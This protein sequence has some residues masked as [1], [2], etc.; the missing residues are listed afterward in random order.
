MVAPAVPYGQ[1]A[2]TPQAVQ[3]PKADIAA[4]SKALQ[5]MAMQNK[6]AQ[7]NMGMQ[8]VPTSAEKAT[9][10]GVQN[11]QSIGRPGEPLEEAGDWT[12]SIRKKKDPTSR[13]RDLVTG[14]S[15]DARRMRE[16]IARIKSDP[17]LIYQ[18]KDE[19]LQQQIALEV[20]K[21]PGLKDRVMAAKEV[22]AEKPAET[23]PATTGGKKDDATPPATTTGGK[24]DDATPPSGK[25]DKGQQVDTSA[26]ADAP[27]QWNKGV[28][29]YGMGL[30]G[31][32]N[33]DVKKM[34]EKLKSL[35]YQVE[36]DGRFGPET[37]K[38]VIQFQ[39]D[40]KIK[41]DGAAGPRT[42]P[43]LAAAKPAKPELIKVL[44]GIK[45][46]YIDQ[47]KYL[48]SLDDIELTFTEDALDQLAENTM[49]LKTGAR[50][51]HTE[52]ERV[53]MPHMFFNFWSD[54]DVF[55]N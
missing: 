16:Y 55:F 23:P 20:N 1:R 51:L 31:E 2:P 35:N 33:E 43:L 46:N 44:T 39:K 10:V 7:P 12:D 36:P 30:R 26:K 17:S 29:G 4:M 49:S 18:I 47:Y 38:A 5:A 54:C 3:D 8:G 42:L 25:D 22:P 19:K 15:P 14:D 11:K 53:L 48:L 37:R 24:K 34:Q 32:P 21:V 27:K 13:A 9:P 45:N 50:G 41:A 52:I 28:L 40:N 6:Q